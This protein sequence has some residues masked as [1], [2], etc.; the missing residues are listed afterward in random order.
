M[1]IDRHTPGPWEV[2]GVHV[3]TK[4]GAINAHGSKAHDHDGWNIATIN[5]WACT[6]QDGEDEDMPVSET[7]ANARLIAAAPELLE[8]LELFGL[9]LSGN[10][11]QDRAEFGDSA[12]DRE[13]IRRAAIARARGE[14]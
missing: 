8:A 13:L 6:N 3:F 14:S 4:L 9:P 11:S 2:V 7:M 12:V 10:D 1:K 5:P